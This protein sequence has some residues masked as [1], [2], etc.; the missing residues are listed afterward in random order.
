MQGLKKVSLWGMFLTKRGTNAS[1]PMIESFLLV[2][3]LSSFFFLN[4][5]LFKKHL[6]G[7]GQREDGG[8]F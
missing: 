5:L 6:Q 8:I 3:M 7:E 4:K 2:W 1:I